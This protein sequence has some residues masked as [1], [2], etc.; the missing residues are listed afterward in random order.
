[1]TPYV[2]TRGAA[3]RTD[4]TG[5]LLGGLATDGGLYVPDA[6]PRLRDIG[7]LRGAPF[8][9]VVAAVLAALGADEAQAAVARG[10]YARFA[11]PA[12][13]P[14]VQTGPQDWILELHHGPTL[15]FK[16]VAMQLLGRLFAQALARSGTRLSVVCAT[17]GDTGGAAAAALADQPNTTLTILFPEG[18]IS[19]VQRRFMTTTGAGNVACLAVDG[20]FDDCQAI[21]KALFADESFRAEVSLAAVNSINWA[22]IAAQAAYYV[23]AALALSAPGSAPVSFSV[24]TGNFGDAFAGVLAKRMGAP[25]GRIVVATNENDVLD[26]ALRTGE[27]AP[28]PVRATHAPS[29]DIQVASNFERMIWEASGRDANIVSDLMSRQSRSE[30]FSLPPALRGRIAEEIE[31][32]AVDD[33][34]GAARMRETLRTTGLLIDPHT[35]IG[36]EAAARARAGGLEGPLVTLATAHAA[37]FPSAVRAATDRTPDL[38]PRREGLM[39]AEET[40]TRVPAATDAVAR[41]IRDLHARAG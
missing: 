14:L 4:F 28:R 8:G 31:T 17:S 41:A 12:V 11:H 36:A 25:V 23:A 13:A 33:E 22:R 2:S 40:M 30:T 5:A 9:E 1:M 10:A 35:A 32:H 34:A 7:A 24:P 21:V 6:W 26:R 18:R 19:E 27:V 37:K 20:T 29:M 39:D 15:A 38:P 16:D 3:A